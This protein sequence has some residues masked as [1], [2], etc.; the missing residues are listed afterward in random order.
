MPVFKGLFVFILKG[1]KLQSQAS[2]TCGKLQLILNVTHLHI[3]LNVSVINVCIAQG[4]KKR[5]FARNSSGGLS[6]LFTWPLE[7]A[8]STVLYLGVSEKKGQNV[9]HILDF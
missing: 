2:L 8:D 5:R 1:K 7:A 9:H 6:S 4:N 3:Y